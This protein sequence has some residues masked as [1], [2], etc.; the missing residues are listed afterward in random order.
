MKTQ[1]S[2]FCEEFEA[3]V[4][5]VL[6]PLKSTAETLDA[7]SD[8][9]A[10]RG[11]LPGVHEVRHRLR[12]LAD[13]VA[14]QQAYVL[15]FGPLKSG[16]STLMNGIAAA[17]VSEVTALPA[18]P[19]MVYVSHGD[20]REFTVTRYN[21]ARETFTDVGAMHDLMEVAHAELAQRLREVEA[22]G[23]EFE[24][25]EHMPTAIRRVDV[26]LPAPDLKESSAVLVDT[27]GLYSRMRFGYDRM[28][29]D[30]R[31][32]AACAVFV[33]KTDNLFLE[34]V[35]DEFEQLLQ[36]F[37]RIFLVVNLDTTKRDL[38][39]DGELGPSLENT[40]P[41]RIVQAFETLSMSAPIKQATE[42]GRLRIYPVDLLNAAASRLHGGDAVEASS[43]EPFLDDLTEY[44]NSTDYLV[45]FLGDSLRQADS[46]LGDISALTA[47]DEVVA[48]GDQ[49][50]H[51]QGEKARCDRE[52]EGLDTLGAVSWKPA[53]ERLGD[54][55]TSITKGR[56]EKLRAEAGQ[57][58]DEAVD[59][60]SEGDASFQSLIDDYVEP[61]IRRCRD[62]LA[63]TGKGVFQ[64][65]AG[66]AT[67]GAT[68]D[69]PAEAALETLK[70]DLGAIGRDVA[71]GL[72]LGRGLGS[73]KLGVD[74]STIPV[75]KGFL[76]WLLF[77]SQASMRKR[78]FG[79]DAD[80]SNPIP[81]HVKTR[82]L[83]DRGFDA[84]QEV[85]DDG[86][87]RYFDG[88]LT[89]LTGGVLDEYVASVKRGVSEAIGKRRTSNQRESEALGRQVRDLTAAHGALG[90]LTSSLAS[91]REQL[92][93]LTQRYGDTDPTEL[94]T[95][96]TDDLAV[97]SDDELA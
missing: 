78:L 28:T 66:N 63:T 56:I 10:V 81:R 41:K 44:L 95:E 45:A 46:V 59:R 40:D 43:F 61:I 15:I 38:R 89:K 74:P 47:R 76:D 68:L 55:L 42:D 51:A 58:I 22:E 67:A 82:K 13:K 36:L 96:V 37:S 53:F 71:A 88:A 72:E 18:Y 4:R 64:T 39:P 2:K 94:T 33:V 92:D 93:D 65:V 80:P 32:S 14:E 8:G 48:L 57:E 6:E 90:A 20:A 77:R 62:D 75:R 21:G 26:R 25:N 79:A 31:D 16:K 54:D 60:W 1:L 86:I 50:S 84:L 27:P 3:V 19:C 29:R 70:L 85:L 69:A 97:A 11:V 9:L 12:T 49:V 91:T 83:G 7:M 35:F 34:Q 24:P 23:G 87:A 17:Y 52:A 30:F 5:P 73:T